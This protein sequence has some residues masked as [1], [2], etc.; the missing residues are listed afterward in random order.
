MDKLLSSFGPQLL[1]ETKGLELVIANFL[2]VQKLFE[3]VS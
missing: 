3:M 2:L 1:W